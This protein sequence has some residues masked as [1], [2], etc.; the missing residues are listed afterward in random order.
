MKFSQLM[1]YNMRNIFLKKSYTQCGAETI[2]RPFFK[3]SKLGISLSRQS[4]ML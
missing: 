3:K 2:S 4:E 1:E